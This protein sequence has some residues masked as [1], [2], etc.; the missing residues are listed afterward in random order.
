MR[1]YVVLG[2]LISS[3]E[4]V[5]DIEQI[6]VAHESVHSLHA[7]PYVLAREELCF[8]LILELCWGQ[9]SLNLGC[10]IQICV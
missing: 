8:F 9:C 2:V 1:L 4:L 7:C 3:L 6:G 10:G 5:V